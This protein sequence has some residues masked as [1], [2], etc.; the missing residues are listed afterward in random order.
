VGAI[1]RLLGLAVLALT[2]AAGIAAVMARS[3]KERFV[4][5]DDPAADEVRLGAFFEPLEFRSTAAAFHGGE[6]ELWFGGGVIDLRGAT[7]DPAGAT[8]SVRAIFGG[9]QIVVPEAWRV[10]SRVMGLGGAGVA[11]SLS[12]EPSEGTSDAP[13]LVVEGT[14]VFGG[15]GIG[16]EVTDQAVEGLRS[17]KAAMA[18][19]RETVQV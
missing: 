19:R 11:P 7:L 18:A 4:P 8:L 15:F 1:A 2:A 9:A 13:H 16:S 3:A 12:P 17:A 10:T 6:V 5:L 14:A